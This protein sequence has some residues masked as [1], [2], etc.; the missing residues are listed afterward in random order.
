MTALSLVVANVER[1]PSRVDDALRALRRELVDGDQV[2]WVDAAGVAGESLVADRVAALPGMGRG[3]LY[4]LGLQAARHELVAF[5]DSATC[6]EPGWRA[7]VI[8]AFAGGADMVGGPVLPGD[9]CSGVSAAGFLV[10]YGPH[11]VPPFVSATG[12]VAANNVA[13]RRSVLTSVVPPD[14]PVWKTV[15]NARLR[16]RGTRPCVAAGMRVVVRKQYR[17]GDLVA[18]RVAAGRLYGAQRGGSWTVSRRSVAALGCA[19]L[20]LLAYCRL[21]RRVATD[22]LLRSALLRNAPLVLLAF[23]AWSVGEALGYLLGDG[24]AHATF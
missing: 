18:G 5:T 3:D 8:A 6:V 7:A 24:K 2:V 23:S 13:Y 21:F 19:V 1:L 20:P 14:A 16:E 12:D 22:P 15:V 17:W 4:R 9:V 10:E 11:A